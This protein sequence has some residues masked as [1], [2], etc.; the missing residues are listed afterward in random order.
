MYREPFFPCCTVST[1]PLYGT[2]VHLPRCHAWHLVAA[3][4]QHGSTSILSEWNAYLC[5]K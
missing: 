4:Q 5:H 1:A 2:E 3:F